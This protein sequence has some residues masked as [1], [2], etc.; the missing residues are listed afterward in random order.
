[1]SR[2]TVVTAILVS[3]AVL[4]PTVVGGGYL[5]NIGVISVIFVMLGAS[6]NL[7]FG[8]T[9]YL[10][11]SHAA[12]FGIG[13]YAAALASTILGWGFIPNLLIGAAGAGGLAFL[14]GAFVFRRVRGFPFAIVTLGVTLTLWVVANHWVDVTRGPLGI[15]GV[16]RPAIAGISFSDSIAYFYLGLVLAGIVVAVC[17]LVARADA[18]RV[19]RAIRDNEVMAAT[20][21]LD[22]Y[23]YKL[24]VYVAASAFAGVTG[25]YYAHYLSVVSPDVFFLYWITTPL[26]IVHVAGLGHLRAVIGVAVALV[27]VPELLRASQ[28]YQQLLFGITLVASVTLLP[29]GVGGW[30]SR[31]TAKR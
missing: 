8:M 11:M 1:M 19:L 27:V 9:G 6:F 5:A 26:V 25:V 31:R 22:T 21:G 7:V 10:V 15:P 29:D 14:T 12:S 30:I 13:A 23:W 2:G 3:I 20:L 17:A 24:W 16:N 18:G 28:A 4:A